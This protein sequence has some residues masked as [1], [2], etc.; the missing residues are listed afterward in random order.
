MWYMDGAVRTSYNSQAVDP[1]YELVGKG[2]FD[3]NHRDDLV[4][5]NP[6]TRQLRMLLSSGVAFATSTLAVVPGAGSRV[7]DVQ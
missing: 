1:A 7:M 2:D 6:D 5:I 3:G 4:A